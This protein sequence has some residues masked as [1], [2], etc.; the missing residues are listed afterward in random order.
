M[1]FA[2]ELVT[3]L[4]TELAGTGTADRP[5]KDLE[6]L[7]RQLEAENA[8]FWVVNVIGGY[9]FSDVPSAGAPGRT[10]RALNLTCGIPYAE[11]RPVE[12]GRRGQ[13]SRPPMGTY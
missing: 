4:R 2:A 10:P 12:F 13:R 9:C 11:T 3:A 5:M 8:D 1:L 7:A 6:A